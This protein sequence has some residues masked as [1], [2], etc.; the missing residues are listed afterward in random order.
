MNEA[1]SKQLTLSGEET[2]RLF[3]FLREKE[4][5]LDRELLGILSQ[6]EKTLYDS[7]SIEELEQAVLVHGTRAGKH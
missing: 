5:E 2:L 1:S 3:L 4:G 7:M 6:V